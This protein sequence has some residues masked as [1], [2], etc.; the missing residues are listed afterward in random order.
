MLEWHQR[1]NG[2]DSEDPPLPLPEIPVSEDGIVGPSLGGDCPTPHHIGLFPLNSIP[3][4]SRVYYT[5][6]GGAK[7]GLNGSPRH[8]YDSQ[9]GSAVIYRIFG[10]QEK[11]IMIPPVCLGVPSSKRV[12]RAHWNRQTPSPSSLS[13]IPVPSLF[14][15]VVGCLWCP[16]IH[17]SA[18]SVAHRLENDRLILYLE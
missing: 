10:R 14:Q 2:R 8:Q 4:C 17:L 5:G 1:R 16:T 15:Y 18:E 13:L 6:T 3:W 9:A 12:P 7:S 11:F